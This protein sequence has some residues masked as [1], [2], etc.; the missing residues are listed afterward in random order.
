MVGDS[1]IGLFMM[2]ERL[3]NRTPDDAAGDED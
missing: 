2:D 3:K 1:E